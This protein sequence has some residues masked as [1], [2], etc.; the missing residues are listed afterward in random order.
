MDLIYQTLGFRNEADYRRAAQIC[1]AT[2]GVPPI[3]VKCAARQSCTV[4]LIDVLSKDYSTLI[5]DENWVKNKCDVWLLIE[6]EAV[7]LLVEETQNSKRYTVQVS[8][9]DE[10]FV[11]ND[12]EFTSKTY[13][14]DL[15]VGDE[16]IFTE[17]QPN[18]ICVSTEI[19]NMRTLKSCRLWC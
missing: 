16:V 5:T 4:D 19:L 17:E 12:E 8:H 2:I 11:I 7:S 18:G 14:F 13:C 15:N 1:A 3:D 9:N 10:F 6:R